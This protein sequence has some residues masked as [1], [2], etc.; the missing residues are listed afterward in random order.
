MVILLVASVIRF[1]SSNWIVKLFGEVRGI[2]LC[3]EVKRF[4][5][6]ILECRYE[7]VLDHSVDLW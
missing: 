1:G 6:L 2:M 5:A 7:S 4:R 3:I